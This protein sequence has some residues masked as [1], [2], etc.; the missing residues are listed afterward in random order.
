MTEFADYGA[1]YELDEQT[2][3]LLRLYAKARRTNKDKDWDAVSKYYDE[4]HPPSPQ[5]LELRKMAY[6]LGRRL[7]E[8]IAELFNKE[9]K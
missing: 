8:S 6:E 3:K 4:I 2:S 5:E 1:V 9:A 7:S